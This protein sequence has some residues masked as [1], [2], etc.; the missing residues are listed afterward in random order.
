MLAINGLATTIAQEL[1]GQLAM[2]LAEGAQEFQLPGTPPEGC[3]RFVFCQGYLAGRPAHLHTFETAAKTFNANFL[4]IAV[5]VDEIMATND[6]ARVVVVGSD[7]GISGSFDTA[8]AAAKAGLHLYVE[9]KRLKP[10]QQLVCVAPGIIEDSGMT[11]R[12]ED[13]AAL[14]LRRRE[15]PKRRFVRAHEVAS[16]IRFLLYEDFGYL[17]GVTIRMVGGDRG[18]R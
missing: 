15:H 17:S 1:I 8:Y 9:T 10:D 18:G 2:H 7:S 4:Q 16:L 13:K 6:Q 5:A 12:R 3:S 14:D 11:Q